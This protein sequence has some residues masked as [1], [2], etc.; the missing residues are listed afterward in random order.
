MSCINAVYVY[1]PVFILPSP[2]TG[3][4]GPDLQHNRREPTCKIACRNQSD[5]TW[6][7]HNTATE[8]WTAH[9]EFL[10]SSW[11]WPQEPEE[12]LEKKRNRSG[13]PPRPAINSASSL[14]KEPERLPSAPKAAQ[15]LIL[16]G[17]ADK[18]T[19]HQRRQA[20]VA[21]KHA[22]AKQ[23]SSRERHTLLSAKENSAEA[24]AVALGRIAVLQ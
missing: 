19:E 23:K 1:W 8:F 18:Q 6:P 4:Q 22:I 11:L 21:N 9:C 2:Y 5:R 10:S 13:A 24:A 3:G 14:Q 17:A 20:R 15:R 12:C 7:P 16:R